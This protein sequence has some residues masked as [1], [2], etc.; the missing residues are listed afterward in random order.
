MRHAKPPGYCVCRAFACVRKAE[1]KKAVEV[2]L[3]WTG[4]IEREEAQISCPF[5]TGLSEGI[6]FN[7]TQREIVWI[8]GQE[9][10]RG[11]SPFTHHRAENSS[12]FSHTP[13]SPEV[14]GQLW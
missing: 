3:C 4:S 12:L 2:S 11:L 7:A 6:A 14:T 5:M 10:R 9:G 8:R 13:L 1:D